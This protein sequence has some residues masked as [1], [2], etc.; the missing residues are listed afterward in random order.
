MVRDLGTSHRLASC[1]IV[2]GFRA[3]LDLD[4][5]PHRNLIRSRCAERAK[6]GRGKPCSAHYAYWLFSLFS[7]HSSRTQSFQRNR[8]FSFLA[9]VAL[10][11]LVSLISRLVACSARIVAD[12]Q[13]NT[14]TDTQKDYC[15][16]RCAC[17]PRVKYS[18]TLL[19]LGAHAQG[20]CCVCLAVCLRLFSHYRLRE[21]L[22]AIPT[23]SVLQGHEKQ[24]GDFAEMTAF[25]RYNFNT[26]RCKQA[27]NQYV[28]SALA[29]LDQVQPV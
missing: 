1:V 12:K 28:K 13:T 5:Y 15:N 29:S 17:A 8:H 20:S 7:R 26:I 11:L 25:E 19:A 16:P 22:R 21:G 2:S 3:A 24:R 10:K 9:L 14:Q 18:C 27:K 6:P 23:A 4:T